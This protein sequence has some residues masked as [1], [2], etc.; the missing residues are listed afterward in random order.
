MKKVKEFYKETPFNF[1]DEIDFYVE[2]IKNINQILEYKDLHN[3]LRRR[4]GLRRSKTINSIIEFGCG[5]GWF[6]NSVSYYYGKKITGIDFTEKAIEKAKSISKQL[7]LKN[8]FKTSDIFNY[9]DKNQYDLVVSLGVLH[10]TRDCENAFK[11]ISKLVKPGGYLY[12]GL[13]HLYGR[14]PMLRFLKG[15]A[16][17]HGDESAYNLFKKMT[18]K[19]DNDQ[20]NYSWFRDQVLHPHETQH[21]LIEVNNWLKQISFKLESCSINKYKSLKNI[22]LNKLDKYERILE[23]HSFKENVEKLSFNPGYFTVCAKNLNE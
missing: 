23:L 18:Q 20:H 2:N 19:S 3:L 13:Y 14:R 11:K 5:T 21:T 17:W 12:I 8:K 1:T 4:N 16:R 7:N 6:T 22:S 9:K 15:Y 10:H